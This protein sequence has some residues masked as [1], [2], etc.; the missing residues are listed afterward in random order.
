MRDANLDDSA[1]NMLR[2]AVDRAELVQTCRE[3]FQISI[4]E[5]KPSEDEKSEARRLTLGAAGLVGV[6]STPVN[7]VKMLKYPLSTVQTHLLLTLTLLEYEIYRI[8]EQETGLVDGPYIPM[9]RYE[10][11]LQKQLFD[12]DEL[13]LAILRQSTLI[14]TY[15]R[16]KIGV[17]QVKWKWTVESAY[18]GENL[19]DASIHKDLEVLK[20]VRNDFA[21]S[22]QSYTRSGTRTG[23]RRACRA[24]LRI[25]A[26]FLSKE[27]ADTFERNSSKH[28]SQ[29]YASRWEDRETS[30]LS[31]NAARLRVKISCDHCG[32]KFDPQ[33]HWKR[34]PH[35]YS[36]HYYWG[37]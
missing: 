10:I 29:R 26:Y 16:R 20:E 4:G 11:I 30:E 3:Y 24:G 1:E 15:L 34:C 9:L 32:Q 31:A 8:L 33:N 18:R 28:I 2:R 14:E 13:E 25:M 19:F 21:H 35:C 5:R 37:P 22:W 6:E 7:K 17:G 12:D 27:L 36:R 23:L